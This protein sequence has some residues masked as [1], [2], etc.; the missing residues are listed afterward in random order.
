MMVMPGLNMVAVSMGFDKVR[1]V[2]VGVQMYEGLHKAMGK[3]KL[4]ATIADELCCKNSELDNLL[5]G[6]VDRD[7]VHI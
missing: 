3:C 2:D 6:R 7:T 5:D 4:N 1:A